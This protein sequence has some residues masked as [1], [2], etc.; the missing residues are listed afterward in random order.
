MQTIY[1]TN[2]D[3]LQEIL[4]NLTDQPTTIHLSN[5]IYRQNM[6]ITNDNL[7]FLGEI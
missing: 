2:N 1:V 4:D 6:I 7:T 3:N 5:G